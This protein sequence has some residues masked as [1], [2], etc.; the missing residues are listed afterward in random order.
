MKKNSICLFIL[1]VAVAAALYGGFPLAL[2][3]R[4]QLTPLAGL[5]LLHHR[6]GDIF[7]SDPEGYTD[8]FIA[9]GAGLELQILEHLPL[10]AVSE[11]ILFFEQDCCGMFFNADLGV[12][13]RF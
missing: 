6:E 8:L 10:N 9:A 7:Y 3:R 2:M 1:L 12:S 13:Y 5:G 4:V 11:Y